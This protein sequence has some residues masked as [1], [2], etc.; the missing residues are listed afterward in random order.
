M[1]VAKLW[2]FRLILNDP[3]GFA[4]GGF[5]MTVRIRIETE[6]GWGECRTHEIGVIVGSI[7]TE[8]SAEIATLL[9]TLRC[10][11]WQGQTDRALDALDV[12][13]RF[14]M[15]AREH[16]YGQSNDAA[17]SVVSRAMDPR[18]YLSHNLSAIANYGRR[19]QQG[20]AI[21]TSRAEGLIPRV[22]PLLS[23]ARAAHT[24]PI[25]ACEPRVSGHQRDKR[26]Q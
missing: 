21:S 17:L 24:A 20:K 3:V 25:G 5:L 18:T 9:E 23:R 6:F 7:E 14:A 19:R 15:R 22:L 8:S 2:G 10:R 11:I 13:F 26:Y 1:G 16:T 12:L 4:A